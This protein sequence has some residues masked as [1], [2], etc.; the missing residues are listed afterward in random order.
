MKNKSLISVII[1]VVG[2]AISSLLIPNSSCLAQETDS[3]PAEPDS[4]EVA[5]A[6]GDST[7]MVVVGGRELF[8][9]HSESFVS[10]K[11]RADAL[12]EAILGLAQSVKA[13]PENLRSIQDDRIQGTVLMCGRTVIGVVWEYEA[14]ALGVETDELA[15]ERLEIIRQAIIESSCLLTSSSS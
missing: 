6:L 12:S 2:I 14:E 13:R 1:G 7:A 10:A 8:E 9:V 11:D 3:P 5:A 4:A 15:Q